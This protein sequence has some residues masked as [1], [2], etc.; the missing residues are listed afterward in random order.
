M[1]RL[2]CWLRWLGLGLVSLVSVFL[3]FVYGKRTAQ[4]SRA[5][6]SEKDAK[7]RRLTVAAAHARAQADIAR[8]EALARLHHQKASTLEMRA[9]QLERDRDHITEDLTE[10]A[11]ELSDVEYIRDFRR[12][13]AGNAAR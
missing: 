8:T 3:A 1:T 5:V 4:V 9:A 12:R 7:A 13:H 10:K 6:A 2:G 11:R